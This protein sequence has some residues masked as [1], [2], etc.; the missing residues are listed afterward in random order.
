MLQDKALSGGRL[1]RTKTRLAS[2]GLAAWLLWLGANAVACR[3]S[4]DGCDELYQALATYD[5]ACNLSVP[6][7]DRWQLSCGA[8]LGLPGNGWSPSACAARVAAATATCSLA[9][10]PCVFTGSL[11]EGIE[12]SLSS[13]CQSGY[14]NA[15]GS[16]SCGAC[17]ARVPAGQACTLT[18]ECVEGSTCFTPTGATA[19]TCTPQA[20]EGASCQNALCL[21]DLTCNTTTMTCQ[22]RVL[23]GGACQTSADCLEGWCNSGSCAAVAYAGPGEPCD[24]AGTRCTH[25]ACPSAGGG[26]PRVCSA[27]AQ[28]GQACGS[29][30][31]CDSYANCV[32]GTCQ[33]TPAV[34]PPPSSASDAGSGSSSSGGSG[35]SSQ[36]C[37]PNTEVSCPCSNVGQY[38]CTG[39]QY[40]NAIGTAYGPCS[41]TC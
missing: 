14:C 13:Q 6:A 37:T 36:V 4:S 31:V 21:P 15:N 12:C 9:E 28:D 2:A 35:G 34:C 30:V 10:T 32:G 8:R 41:C 39:R 19:G 23:L 26:G 3:G 33:L 27:V 18:A 29:G 11:P 1:G 17:T 25:G 5:Q 16:S 38:T 24:G 40:C 7:Q 20:S 22:R